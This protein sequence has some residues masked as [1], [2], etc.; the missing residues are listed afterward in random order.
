[1]VKAG[2]FRVVLGVVVSMATLTP[3]RAWAGGKDLTGVVNLNTAEVGLLILLPGV[4][5]AKAAQIVAY[6]S[7]HP[8][9]TVDELVRIKGIG[10]RMVRSLRPHLAV[11]GP[12]TGT[13]TGTAKASSKFAGAASIA[14]SAVG[15]AAS[16]APPNRACPGLATGAATTRA[17]VASSS[18]VPRPPAHNGRPPPSRRFELVRTS[19]RAP[20]SRA[21]HCSGDTS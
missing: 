17:N 8:F 10:R 11:A 13:G 4:G 14:A 3:G 5:S 15:G 16:V 1:M 18:S 9:R 2:V 7:R 20:R 19:T 6:R 12:S 21:N